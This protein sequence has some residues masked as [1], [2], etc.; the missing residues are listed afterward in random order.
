MINFYTEKPNRNEYK[1]IKAI[2]SIELSVK[3]SFFLQKNLPTQSHQET[4]K[5][6][7]KD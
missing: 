4:T 6:T 1:I 3:S 5:D 7:K 2:H